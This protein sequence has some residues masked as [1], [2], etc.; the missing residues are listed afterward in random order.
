[1]IRRER[2]L[3]RIR[4][5]VRIGRF[6]CLLWS[7]LL[8]SVTGFAQGGDFVQKHISPAEAQELVNTFGGDGNFVILDVRTPA[9][10]QAE[11]IQGAFL[12]DYLAGTFRQEMAKLDRGKT[13]L[14]YCRTGSRSDGALQVMKEQ[15]FR[16]VYHLDGGIVKWKEAGLPTA[17]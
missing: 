15:G 4:A 17:K 16:N 7:V 10:F 6:L 14:V 8:W 13:Y 2:F 12:V 9:E 1:M 11:R 3:F 5:G